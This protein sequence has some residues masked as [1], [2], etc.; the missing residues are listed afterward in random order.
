MIQDNFEAIITKLPANKIRDTQRDIGQII[1]FLHTNGLNY[2][3][4]IYQ[5]TS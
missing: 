2:S 3:N 4:Y 1:I 5:A